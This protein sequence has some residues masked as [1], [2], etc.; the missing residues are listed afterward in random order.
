MED[1]RF[2]YSC[3]PENGRIPLYVENHLAADG[4]LA[5]APA[6]FVM[7]WQYLL[8]VK[9]NQPQTPAGSSTGI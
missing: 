7:Y 1:W 2:R 6:L 4:R 5:R 3:R 9:L 8:A